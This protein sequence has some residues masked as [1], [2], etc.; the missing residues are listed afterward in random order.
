MGVPHTAELDSTGDLG[1]LVAFV[2]GGL[3]RESR[4]LK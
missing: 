1:A 2:A 3:E 4:R